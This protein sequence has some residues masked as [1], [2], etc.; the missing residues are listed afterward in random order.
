MVVL[1]SGLKCKVWFGFITAS[2]IELKALNNN[3]NNKVLSIATQHKLNFVGYSL[4]SNTELLHI[5]LLCY[6]DFLEIKFCLIDFSLLT[7]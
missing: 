2:S 7:V 5:I 6:F 4:F 1:L 3:N